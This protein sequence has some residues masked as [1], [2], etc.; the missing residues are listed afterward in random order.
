MKSVKLSQERVVKTLQ[1][2][3]RDTNDLYLDTY[4]NLYHSEHSAA[5][6]TIMRVAGRFIDAL[7]LKY[8]TSEH[9]KVINQIWSV[10][11]RR[12]FFEAQLKKAKLMK[13][14]AK[15]KGKKPRD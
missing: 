6:S 3:I 9:A 14:R 10:D 2:T 12:E 8:T 7:G 11:R 15:Q 1:Q 13:Q 5:I 4:N